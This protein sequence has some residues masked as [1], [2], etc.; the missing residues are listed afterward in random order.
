MEHKCYNCKHWIECSHNHGSSY[1]GYCRYK[2]D[3][4]TDG[5]D[6][7]NEWE[8]KI[9]KELREINN[10]YEWLIKNSEH[11][12]F[13]M[14]TKRHLKSE[15]IYTVT[16]KE[17][18]QSLSVSKTADNHYSILRI[19]GYKVKHRY[20]SYSNEIFKIFNFISEYVKKVV[21]KEDEKIQQA[22][23]SFKV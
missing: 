15:L 1:S 11:L 18:K 14:E 3:E 12:S 5:F 2:A 6:T 22:I 4:I 10:F 7:C 21:D 20:S 17:T 8:D 13:D 9:T 16:H 19:N 23:D